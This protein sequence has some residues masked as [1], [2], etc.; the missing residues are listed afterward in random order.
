MFYLVFIMLLAISLVSTLLYAVICSAKKADIA[1]EA[2]TTKETK[3]HNSND[4]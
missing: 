1:H 3:K 4:N 2:V